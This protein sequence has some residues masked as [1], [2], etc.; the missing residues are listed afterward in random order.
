MGESSWK[1][2]LLSSGWGAKIRVCFRRGFAELDLQK[3]FFFF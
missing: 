1:G 3:E 2:H